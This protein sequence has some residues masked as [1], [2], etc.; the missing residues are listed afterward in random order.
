[1]AYFLMTMSRF[2]AD[3]QCLPMASSPSHLH[4]SRKSEGAPSKLCS[5]KQRA[6]IV[7]NGCH[8]HFRFDLAGRE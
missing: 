8:A 6:V 3:M 7:I 1:L 2:A 5:A 4:T